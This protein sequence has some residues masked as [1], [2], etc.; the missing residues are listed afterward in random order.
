MAARGSFDIPADELGLERSLPPSTVPWKTSSPP[1]QSRS[2]D[3]WK[4]ASSP[5]KAVEAPKPRVSPPRYDPEPELAMQS[6]WKPTWDGDVTE[7]PTPHVLPTSRLAAVE[8]APDEDDSSEPAVPTPMPAPKSVKSTPVSAQQPVSTRNQFP[9]VVD[10]PTPVWGQPWRKG[11][12]P[13]SNT[14]SNQAIKSVHASPPSPPVMEKL[15]TPPLVT[16]PATE[17]VVVSTPT[18]LPQ[19]KPKTAKQQR[20]ERN[21]KGKNKA[22]A[23]MAKEDTVEYQEEVPVLPPQESQPSVPRKAGLDAA[24]DNMVNTGNFQSALEQ[25]N[26][27]WK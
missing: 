13:V 6:F 4:P 12:L 11:K 27:A 7:P 23:T 9:R 24:I 5:P 21:R 8:D 17:P 16:A 2:S 1:V 26:W 14:L 18:P 15:P 22:T 25:I 10:E 19:T 20:A 3:A